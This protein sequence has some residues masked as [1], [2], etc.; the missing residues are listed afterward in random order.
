MFRHTPHPS[1]VTAQNARHV[2][3]LL[4]EVLDAFLRRIRAAAISTARSVLPDTPRRSWN[5]RAARPFSAD[6]TEIRRRWNARRNALRPTVK[7]AGF[8]RSGI[9]LLCRC[10]GRSRMGQRGRRAA[11]HRRILASAR[12]DGT[13]F[14]PARR[15]PARH[16]HGHGQSLPPAGPGRGRQPRPAPW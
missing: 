14:F 15:C 5:A 16:A 10:A 13:R 3:V 11:R 7:T 12:R 8:F 4:N 2:S 1:P 6:S 9:R